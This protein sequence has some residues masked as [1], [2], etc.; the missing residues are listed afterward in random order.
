[1]AKPHPFLI[2]VVRFWFS[3]SLLHDDS[4]WIHVGGMHWQTFWNN[5]KSIELLLLPLSAGDGSRMVL[6]GNWRKTT[7]SLWPMQHSRTFSG[8]ATKVF[9]CAQTQKSN[10]IWLR[11][12]M[13]VSVWI[14]SAKLSMSPCMG[15]ARMPLRRW[16]L[17][18]YKQKL[19]HWP[20]RMPTPLIF[21]YL[22]SILVLHQTHFGRL[23]S[24]EAMMM[25]MMMLAWSR[26][27]DY[28]M[29]CSCWQWWWEI[30]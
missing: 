11:G 25:M 27:Y 3:L 30:F 20:Q 23:E 5:A 21:S 2:I 28:K 6:L 7:F 29:V 26:K 14:L 18:P 24:A 1:M 4:C 22:L 8:P 13:A 17:G 10:S 16:I 9:P 12:C 19:R 15:G